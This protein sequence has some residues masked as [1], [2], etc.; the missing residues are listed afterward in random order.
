MRS[1]IWRALSCGALL[2]AAA[3]CSN[4]STPPPPAPPSAPAALGTAKPKVKT[5]QPADDSASS[6]LQ[7][8]VRAYLHKVKLP[9]PPDMKLP[10]EV[11]VKLV[12]SKGD[13]VLALDTKAAPLHVRSFVYLCQKKFYDGTRFHRWANLTENA[14]G[15]KPGYIIQGGDPLSRDPATRNSA[16]MGGPGYQI[17]REYNSLKHDPLVVA[18]ARSSDPDSAGSQFYIT[19]NAVPFLDQGDGY[20]VF[21][22]VISGEKAAVALRQ[23]DVLKQA[24]VLK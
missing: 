23:D 18:A 4:N 24:V 15:A 14:K 19:Q 3:G 8:A 11:K 9:P 7:P 13:I 6:Q 10:A 12:T 16:G 5:Y 1:L 21:G 22:K 17:P 20:T 2:A